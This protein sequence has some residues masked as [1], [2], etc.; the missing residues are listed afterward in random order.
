M[1]DEQSIGHKNR[2]SDSFGMNKY[3]ALHVRARTSKNVVFNEKKV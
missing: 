3:C 1:V 2:L